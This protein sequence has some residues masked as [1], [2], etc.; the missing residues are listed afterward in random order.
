MLAFVIWWAL[1]G[2]ARITGFKVVHVIGGAYIVVI[3]IVL[4]RPHISESTM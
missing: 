4:I 3:R 2:R 1:G